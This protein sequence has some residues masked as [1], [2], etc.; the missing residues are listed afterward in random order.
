M[1]VGAQIQAVKLA[2]DSDPLRNVTTHTFCL[3]EVG[4]LTD[5]ELTN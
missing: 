3:F 2:G 5:L 1:V 4:S